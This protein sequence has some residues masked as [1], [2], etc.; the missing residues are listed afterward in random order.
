MLPAGGR[1]PGQRAS[2]SVW[3][4]GRGEGGEGGA[5]AVCLG[6]D[7]NLWA[8]REAKCFA[9]QLVGATSHRVRFS[10]EQE[11]HVGYSLGLSVIYL[12]G[13]YVALAGLETYCVDQAVLKS[14]RDLCVPPLPAECWVKG[15]C[16]LASTLVISSPQRESI[17]RVTGQFISWAVC[18][19]LALVRCVLVL[20][21]FHWGKVGFLAL[22]VLSHFRVMLSCLC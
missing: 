19:H 6:G 20:K 5:G 11:L 9:F 8:Q 4:W 15:V 2:G 17:C 18:I 22:A 21:N 10:T 1:G 3:G 16:H 12:D 7:G 13:L 14:L